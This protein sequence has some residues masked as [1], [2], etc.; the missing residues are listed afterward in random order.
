[1]AARRTAAGALIALAW[2]LIGTE[3]A[4][5]GIPECNNVRLEDG[6]SC[7]IRGEVD[8]NVGCDELGVYKKACATKLHTVCREVCTL[9]A[10]AGCTD[11]CTVSCSRDCDLGIYVICSHN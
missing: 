10:D 3:S 7:E 2:G 11:E 9:T 5:A 6:G 1:M 8:C 4:H